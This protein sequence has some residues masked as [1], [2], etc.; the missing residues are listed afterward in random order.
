MRSLKNTTI[1]LVVSSDALEMKKP[2]NRKKAARP[3]F[4]R[5]KN[6]FWRVVSTG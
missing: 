4:P 3:R 1:F 6:M 2:E 5:V